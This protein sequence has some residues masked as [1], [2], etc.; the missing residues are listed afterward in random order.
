MGS[1]IPRVATG[2]DGFSRVRSRQDAASDPG[3]GAR[4]G[5]AIGCGAEVA[6]LLVVAPWSTPRVAKSRMRAGSGAADPLNSATLP[7]FILDL[8][9]GPTTARHGWARLGTAD[10]GSARSRIQDESGAR[11]DSSA[12]AG[13]HPESLTAR[14]QRHGRTIR[15][16]PADLHRPARPRP[17]RPRR[18]SAPPRQPRQPVPS[19]PPRQPVP[20][21]RSRSTPRPPSPSSSP[22]G[23][24]IPSRSW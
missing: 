16:S 12:T 10:H 2:G 14:L 24:S 18:P 4:A 5:A 9:T 1:D 8:A 13:I 3:S 17:A 11:V 6:G 21:V 22:R 19:A 7:S 20:R 15:A 23:A